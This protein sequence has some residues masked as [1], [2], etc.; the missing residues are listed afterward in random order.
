MNLPRRRCIDIKELAAKL[1]VSERHLFRLK[2]AGKL[3]PPVKI[4]RCLRWDE[5]EIDRWLESG[6]NAG[7]AHTK[8]R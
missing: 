8:R 4:G 7:N 1:D 2:T 6:G 3:P 5:A